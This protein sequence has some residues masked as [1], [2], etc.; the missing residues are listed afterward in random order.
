MTT[1]FVEGFERYANVVQ[2]DQQSFDAAHWVHSYYAPSRAIVC[3]EAKSGFSSDRGQELQDDHVMRH[4]GGAI[5]WLLPAIAHVVAHAAGR[6]RRV[7]PVK[8]DIEPA[9]RD[10]D[11]TDRDRHFVDC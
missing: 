9:N 11:V 8:A 2:A 1:T 4:Y 6:A 10:R 5:V 3:Y 7:I